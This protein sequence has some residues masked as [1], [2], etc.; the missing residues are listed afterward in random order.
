[1]TRVL[2]LADDDCIRFTCVEV[3]ARAGFHASSAELAALPAEAPEAVLLLEKEADA[4]AT[5][6]STYPEVPVLV[7]TWDHRR[8]WPG[9]DAVIQL[10]FNADRV[11]MMLFKIIRANQ[12][13]ARPARATAA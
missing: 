6:R 8:A 3:L 5:V 1:M 11:S 2:I 9:A 7:C 12:I 13:G 4:L 10:P